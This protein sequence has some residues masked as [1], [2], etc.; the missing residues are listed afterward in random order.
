VRN[1]QEQ[2]L[3]VVRTGRVVAQHRVARTPLLCAGDLY[4]H[5]YIYTHI[6][7]HTYIYICIYMYTSHHTYMSVNMKETYVCVV[8]MCEVVQYRVARMFVSSFCGWIGLFDVCW[9]C[10]DLFRVCKGLF[11]VGIVLSCGSL[12]W[13][14]RSLLRVDRSLWC[15]QSINRG[16][17]RL[18]GSSKSQVSF[19]EY[20]LFYRA[21]LQKRPIV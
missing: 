5:I 6:Y 16:W 3:R 10:K 18:A 2:G 9:V 13:V 19:A 4:I 7:M 17:L 1:V 8:W 20:R 21:L 11:L 15:V 14:D 12:L